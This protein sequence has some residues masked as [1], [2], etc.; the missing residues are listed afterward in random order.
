MSIHH[1]VRK[2][3]N[4]VNEPCQST[5]TCYVEI[6]VVVLVR[7]RTEARLNLAS[8]HQSQT[9]LGLHLTF[10]EWLT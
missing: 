6:A 5:L 7:A 2:W 1:I 10:L 3:V 9:K 8:Q 4:A